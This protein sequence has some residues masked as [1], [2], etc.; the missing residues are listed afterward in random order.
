[1]HMLGMPKDM[2]TD[3]RYPGGVVEE[4]L[5]FLRARVEAVVAKGV[6]PGQLIID[7]GIGFGKT[8]THN[9]T[10][11]QGIPDLRSLGLPVLIGASRKWFIGQV[12]GREVGDRLSG[13]LAAAAAAVVAGADIVRAHEVEET[14]LAVRV[15]HAIVRPDLW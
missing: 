7:P 11:L 3:P 8:V 14:V 13:S 6:D 1:M 2:Q 15:A 9:L 5:E 10:I 12:T 4:I